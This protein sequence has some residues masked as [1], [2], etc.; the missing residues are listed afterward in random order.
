MSVVKFANLVSVLDVKGTLSAP[1]N[2]STISVTCSPEPIPANE[3][4]TTLLE[5]NTLKCKVYA[6]T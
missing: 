4:I 5:L 3:I 1:T 2:A 6:L